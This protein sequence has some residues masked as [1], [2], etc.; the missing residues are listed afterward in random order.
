[1]IDPTNIS[2]N[3]PSVDQEEGRQAASLRA[4]TR[5]AARHHQVTA[6]P[7][8]GRMHRPQ[9]TSRAPARSNRPALADDHEHAAVH[10]ERE[11]GAADQERPERDV[12]S[13]PDPPRRQEQQARRGR[14]EGSGEQGGE[15]AGPAE[16]ETD[17]RDE[18]EVT[19]RQ[20]AAH[21]ERQDAEEA[22][23]GAGTDERHEWFHRRD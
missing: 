1:M 21:D 10:E 2:P 7:L 20:A 4:A 17:G 9:G 18:V 19:H 23:R 3:T 11:H 15:D 12:A 8:E 14:H 13:H 22:D 6:P 5:G 16:H